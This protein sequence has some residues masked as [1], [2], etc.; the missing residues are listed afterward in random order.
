M[1]E[2]TDKNQGFIFTAMNFHEKPEIIEEVRSQLI[3]KLQYNLR[4]KNTQSPQNQRNQTYY[5]YQRTHHQYRRNN[6]TFVVIQMLN[7]DI[8]T[9]CFL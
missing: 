9:L 2:K 4:S 3:Q 8:K 1:S 6:T 7:Q 5:H